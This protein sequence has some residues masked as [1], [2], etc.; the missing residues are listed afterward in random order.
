[1]VSVRVVRAVSVESL[2]LN[3]CCVVVK[4]YVGKKEEEGR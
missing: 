1:M 3:P 2:G 4:L